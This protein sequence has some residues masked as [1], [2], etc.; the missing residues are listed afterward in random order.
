MAKRAKSSCTYRDS[1]DDDVGIFG[2]TQGS[3]GPGIFRPPRHQ[4]PIRELHQHPLREG[5]GRDDSDSKDG[6]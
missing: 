1:S 5:T 3:G 6:D 4:G 2:S